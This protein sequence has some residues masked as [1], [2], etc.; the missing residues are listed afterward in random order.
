MQYAENCIAS[1]KLSP[2][3]R[4][5]DL[6]HYEEQ[7]DGGALLKE[8]KL[9]VSFSTLRKWRLFVGAEDVQITYK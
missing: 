7:K 5:T 9:W 1:T 2:P 8:L 4:I 6:I 3:D